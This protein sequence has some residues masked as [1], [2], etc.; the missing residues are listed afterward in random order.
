[1]TT[2]AK[3]GEHPTPVAEA[4]DALDA[5]LRRFVGDDPGRSVAVHLLDGPPLRAEIAADIPRPAGS[6]LKLLPALALYKAAKRSELDLDTSVT[7]GSLGTTA[8]PSILAAFPD[9]RPLTLREVC[10]FSLITSDN[11]A[12]EQIRNLVGSARI[13]EICRELRLGQT[14]LN[15][16]FSDDDLGVSG[17]RNVSTAREALQLIEHVEGAP[18]LDELRH[19]LVNN[20]RNTRIPARLD[21]EV[22][23]MHKTGTLASVVNDVGMVH[24]PAGRIAL[25]YLCDNQQDT[26]LASIDI[27]DSALRIVEIMTEL[28][29][30][31]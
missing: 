7:R 11:P 30:H 16:G 22:P 31:G 6:L 12:A 8:Y 3:E 5:E 21:D 14:R 15:V 24:H 20:L 13:A 2:T 25:A 28:H 27:G 9:D 26:A 4:Q 18:G 17:R 23:V 1:M 19:F 10:A 29:D